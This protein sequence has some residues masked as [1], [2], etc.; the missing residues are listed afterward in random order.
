[1]RRRNPRRGARRLLPLL[2]AF[3]LSPL[4]SRAQDLTGAIGVARSSVA[5]DRTA[6]LA[7]SYSHDFTRHLSASV[8]YLN[9]GHVPGHHRDGFVPQLWL[10]SG[11]LLAR[12]FSLAAGIG[13]YH[14]FDTVPASSGAGYEDRR[15]W[16]VVYSLA[17]TLRSASSP[18]LYQLRFNR[19]LVNG[20]GMDT[21]TV[22]VGI[23]Y[24]LDPDERSASVGA[25]GSGE[26]SRQQELT[27]L[28]GRS[29]VNS[30]ESERAWAKAIEYRRTLGSALGGPAFPAAARGSILVLDEGDGGGLTHRRGVA[31]QGWLEPSFYDER[32]T[33]GAGLGP[34]LAIDDRRAAS[35][36]VLSGLL[37]LTASYRLGQSWVVRATFN[38]V[39]S[40]YHRDTDVLLLG[41]GYRF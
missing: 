15:G 22:L 11:E 30:Y 37:S 20:G 9:E 41:L 8:S 14:Y 27:L 7:L 34:Y 2:L 35:G 32:L 36:V 31:A 25:G 3:L 28:G 16:G 10:A 4:A 5:T 24:R 17:A 1:M 40:G 39:M 23:G 38:R 21:S 18:W 6:A 13:P 19:V 33:L 12:R 26:V 29:I